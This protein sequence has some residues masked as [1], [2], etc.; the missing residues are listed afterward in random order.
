MKKF[1]KT[2]FLIISFLFIITTVF[3]QGNFTIK[4]FFLYGSKPSKGYEKAEKRE[5][6]GLHGGHVSIGIDSFVVSF[7]HV[8]GY[9]FFPHHTNL[10]G[11]Y[12][13]IGTSE[14]VKDTT[15][16]KYTTFVIPLDSSQ[17][18]NLQ[19]LVLFYYFCA[20][21]KQFGNQTI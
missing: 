6:G 15:E 14:F 18:N 21:S 10:K 12:E 20:S 17:Y 16:E 2:G 7:H 5:F 3:A 9:H 11:V 8:N 4:V 1:S 13:R 19:Y